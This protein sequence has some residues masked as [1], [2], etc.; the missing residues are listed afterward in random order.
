MGFWLI[1]KSMTT[2]TTSINSVVWKPTT[3]NQ[4]KLAPYCLWQKC[5]PKNLGFLAK[6]ALCADITVNECIKRKM[7]TLGWK[8]NE[9][10]MRCKTAWPA[11]CAISAVERL[12][13]TQT[14]LN[15][16]NTNNAKIVKHKNHNFDSVAAYD[17]S[18]DEFYGYS[19]GRCVNT[20]PFSSMF[21]LTTVSRGR[22]PVRHRHKSNSSLILDIPNCN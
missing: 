9:N 20:R 21:S 18:S 2:F 13:E 6:Y 4:I 15:L 12:K 14:E 17:E 22:L 3:S 7:Y 11:T 16:V 1:P 10:L 5:S 8:L 19:Y